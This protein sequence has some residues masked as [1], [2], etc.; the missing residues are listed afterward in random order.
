MAK[1]VQ[2]VALKV[3]KPDLEYDERQE[4]LHIPRLSDVLFDISYAHFLKFVD[5]ESDPLL[6]RLILNNSLELNLFTDISNVALKNDVRSSFNFCMT[7]H[8]NRLVLH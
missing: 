6:S 1:K 7:Y 4:Y 5:N 8:D 2:R 3:I